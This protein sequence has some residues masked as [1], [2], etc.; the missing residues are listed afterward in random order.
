MTRKSGTRKGFVC[1]TATLLASAA[2]AVV[3]SNPHLHQPTF[4]CANSGSLRVT[5]RG[6]FADGSSAEGITVRVLD[7][8]DRV[9]YVGTV[10]RLGRVSFRKPDAEF[11]VVF[12]AGGGNVL[13]LL[14]AE[15]T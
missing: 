12:D 11:T 8:R 10:D 7:K 9:V 14:G 6:A 5:C 15:M 13:T 1:A 4:Q 3:A 2:T